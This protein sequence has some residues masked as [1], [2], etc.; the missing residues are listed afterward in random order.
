MEKKA[1]FDGIIFDVDGTIWDTTSVVAQA[2][3]KA[4]DE[5]FPNVKHVDSDILKGQFGKT[6]DVIGQ[7]LFSILNK[8]EQKILMDKCAEEE[9]T[10]LENTTEN[11]K[12]DGI[13]E[14]IQKLSE[15]YP[16]FIVSNCQDGYI[17]VVIQ[18]NNLGEYIKDTECFGVTGLNKDENIK[19]IVKRNNL[20]NPVYVGDTQGDAEAC[21]SAKVPFIWAKYGFGQVDENSCFAQINSPKDLLE[22]L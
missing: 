14:A 4:I 22:I 18:K 19:L 6:M 11:L 16:L 1:D 17:P 20:K 10:F 13:Y 2:W 9:Q 5:N 15:K 12:Y 8:D 3:N 7:N 21:R